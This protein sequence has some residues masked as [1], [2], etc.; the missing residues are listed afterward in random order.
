MKKEKMVLFVTAV[1][2]FAATASADVALS[3]DNAEIVALD[4]E[5]SGVVQFAA[6]ELSSLLGQ[7]FGAQVPVVNAPTEGKV[8]IVLGS[9]DW[10]RAAGID[11]AAL[12]RDAFVIKVVGGKVYIAGRDAPGGASM[13]KGKHER[14]TLFGVYEFLHRYVGIRMY[15]PG[16]RAT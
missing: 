4:S 1:A 11:T 14:A 13:L 9:N 12:E 8:S 16:E 15:F 2:L 3:R 6:K 5:E 7:A 10:S